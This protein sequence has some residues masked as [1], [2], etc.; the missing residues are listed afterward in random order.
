MVKNTRVVANET[1]YP[2]IL[3]KTT[4]RNELL[5]DEN[6]ASSNN[7]VDAGILSL[8]RVSRIIGATA[9]VKEYS[10]GLSSYPLDANL[11]KEMSPL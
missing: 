9:W 6:R 2:V 11:S 10:V 5:L 1:P 7:E 8:V 4:L 3:F